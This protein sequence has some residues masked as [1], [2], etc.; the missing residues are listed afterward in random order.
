MRLLLD[1][2]TR[3]W[4]ALSDPQL[5]TTAESQIRDP[6][7]AKLVSPA[8]YW[9]IANKMRFSASRVDVGM[10]EPFEPVL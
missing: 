4:F 2:H 3:L 7:H 8:S 1:T 6:S 5:S 10:T 9:E